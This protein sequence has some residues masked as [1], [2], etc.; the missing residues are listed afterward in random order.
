[1][2][3]GVN[4]THVIQFENELS[5]S[6]LFNDSNRTTTAI[7]TNYYSDNHLR[8]TLSY[9]LNYILFFHKNFGASVGLKLRY[10]LNP[11]RKID[12]QSLRNDVVIQR[13]SYNLQTINFSLPVIIHF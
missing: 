12:Y 10:D 6:F 9:S 8:F 3:F 5:I 2:L 13:G 7:H 11:M 4:G 1:M